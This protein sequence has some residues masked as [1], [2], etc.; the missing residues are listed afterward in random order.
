[1]TDPISFAFA[2]PRFKLPLLFAGQAQ[3]E[4]AVNEA[5]AL[6]D[7]LLHLAVEGEAMDPPPAPTEGDC[8]VVGT[9]AT[10]DWTGHDGE[11][12]C[13]EAGTWLFVAPRDGLRAF[14]RG[15]GQDWRYAAG[16]HV[17]STVV[18]PAGGTTIDMEARVAI[19]AIIQALEAGGILPQS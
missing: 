5:H 19:S 17:A 9:S 10:G 15:A 18:E 16:W 2:S 6:T 4:F 11:I 13:Y 7:A 8:W 3:K 14:N 12:A 1:M